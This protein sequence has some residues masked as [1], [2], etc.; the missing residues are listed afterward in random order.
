[1]KESLRLI[2][3]EAEAFLATLPG[4]MRPIIIRYFRNKVDIDYK[5]DKSPVTLADREVENKLRRAIETQFSTHAI[6]GEEYGGTSDTDLC[7]IIDPI[8]GTRAFVIGSP[9]FGMLVGLTYQGMPLCGLADMPA[10]GESYF[11]RDGQSW[12][13]NKDGETCLASRDGSKL[14][15]AHIG[16]TSPEAFNAD[17]LA[18]FNA[19][20]EQCRSTHYGGDCYNYLLLASGYLDLV[21]EHQLAAHDLLP[22]IPILENA[23]AVISD[24]DGKPI[25]LGFDGSVLVAANSALHAEA[26]RVIQG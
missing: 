21:V 10:L 18:C 1:M 5:T 14:A 11:T 25:T 16:T 19:L 3:D 7:W 23:G 13:L 12:R 22:L 9:L 20:S 24:W 17:G 4:L 6:I 15:N 26:I 2:C 8:D